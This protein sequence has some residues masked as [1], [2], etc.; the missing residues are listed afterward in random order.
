MTNRQDYYDLPPLRTQRHFVGSTPTNHV[1]TSGR[2]I[3]D[4]D[5]EM[6]SYNKKGTKYD[7]YPPQ[8]SNYY[9]SPFYEKSA[10]DS[11]TRTAP[12]PPPNHNPFNPPVDPFATAPVIMTNNN[13]PSLYQRVVKFPLFTYLFTLADVIY[14]I[15]ELVKMHQLTG[16]VIQTQPYINP[17]LGPS[18]YVQIYL[19]SRFK[20]CAMSSQYIDLDYTWPCPN[21]TTT[22]TN[23]CSLAELCSFKEDTNPLQVWRIVSACFMHAGFIHIIFNMLLQLTMGRDVEMEIGWWR[24][25]VIY[26]LSGVSG[27]LFGLNF[28]GDGVSSTGA[29]GA[30]F[31]IIAV[32]LVSFILYKDRKRIRGYKFLVGVLVGEIIV[33]LV[34]GL[35][36]GLDNFAHIGGF[37]AGLLCSFILLDNP[38][39]VKV[40]PSHKY[41]LMKSHENYIMK[42]FWI[43]SAVRV[44]SL[45]LLVAWFIGLGINIKN[46]GGNCSWCKYLS[47]LPVNGW[48]EQSDLTTS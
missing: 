10:W 22:L 16:K 38:R 2:V 39:F 1:N 8:T 44:V 18:S 12:P 3:N 5:I 21:S 13:D 30:L 19:G 29:S 42:K 20:P 48:C 14:F 27:N 11:S 26:I 6:T 28:A 9:E 7:P 32:N 17:M 46:G 15:V 25:F 41:P 47:C 36:P 37:V 43:W 34:L 23:V 35:L 40:K 45:A 4:E 33:C 24:Y 31:G